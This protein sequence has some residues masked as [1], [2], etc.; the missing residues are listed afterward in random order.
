MDDFVWAA[1]SV[2]GS[3]HRRIGKN[4]QDAFRVIQS[5][6]CL[7]GLV[8]DGCGSKVHSE[9]GAWLGVEIAS[10]AIANYLHIQRDTSPTQR[11]TTEFLVQLRQTIIQ[12]F[13]PQL[14]IQDYC[15]FTL[16]GFVITEQETV[17][18]GCG[19][20]YMVLN[21]EVTHWQFPHN[22]PPY[23][24]YA[25]AELDIF[26]QCPTADLQS[27]LIATDGVDDWNHP[28]GLAEFWSDDHLFRNPDQVR[29]QLTVANK[30]PPYL[31]DDTTLIT[32]K[33]RAAA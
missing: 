18:F 6:G 19:D 24:V 28:H 32:V 16:L 31:R 14:F 9:V 12:A 8:A 22:A 15:L 21:G 23:L 1:G 5:A 13:P 10:Q 3:E 30:Q 25:D 4:N 29:R 17:I 2:I 7:V 20:G 26:A 11:L 33:R 27:L